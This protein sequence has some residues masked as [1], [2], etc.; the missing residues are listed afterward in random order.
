MMPR[1]LVAT[2]AAAALVAGLSGCA[3]PAVDGDA[4]GQFQDSVVAIAE[5]A[6]AGDVAGAVG[7]LDELQTELNAAMEADLVTA[8]RAARI[9]A[10]IDT[11]RSDLDALQAPAP[12]ETP[13]SVEP[14][15]AGGDTAGT[16]AGGNENSGPGNNNG[17]ENSGPGNNNGN[18]NG[19]GNGHGK[20]AH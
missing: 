12:V 18:G 14:T 17:N 15:T 2:L 5:S 7:G 10:A 13:A 1:A 6:A 8:A 3:T 4:A 9:Q 16:G 19:N 20:K 11:V